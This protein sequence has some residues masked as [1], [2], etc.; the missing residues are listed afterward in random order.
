MKILDYDRT[1]YV[2][3]YGLSIYRVDLDDLAVGIPESESTLAGNPEVTVYPN[4]VALT[5][6]R[7]L[8]IDIALKEAGYLKAV[9]LDESGRTVYSLADGEFAKDFCKLSWNGRN[10]AGERMGPGLYFLQ[11]T[12]GSAGS[13]TKI[14]VL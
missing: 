4:P 1:L 8:S 10:G 3:T 5:G 13:I 7:S 11:V 2:G 14:V 12:C 9:I 6:A